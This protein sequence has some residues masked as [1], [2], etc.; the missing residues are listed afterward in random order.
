MVSFE[1]SQ[2]LNL[3]IVISS[4]TKVT[5]SN[6]PSCRC[7][8]FHS[9]WHH[10]AENSSSWHESCISSSR[11]IHTSGLPKLGTTLCTKR[12]FNKTSNTWTMKSIHWYVCI[13]IYNKIFYNHMLNILERVCI[14]DTIQERKTEHTT[15]VFWQ[16]LEVCLLQAPILSFLVF[17]HWTAQK[18]SKTLLLLLLHFSVPVPCLFYVPWKPPHRMWKQERE[19]F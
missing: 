5:K 12:C 7:V 14:E 13:Y 6:S 16:T 15:I 4:R 10:I 1:T 2:R 8:W 18:T 17:N 3:T 11:N 19:S 9:L